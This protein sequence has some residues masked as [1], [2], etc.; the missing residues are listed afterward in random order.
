MQPVQQVV[1]FQTSK[2]HS[3][4]QACR[5]KPDRYHIAAV[6]DN[7]QNCVYTKNR[8]PE[9]MRDPYQAVLN[10]LLVDGLIL[11]IW[12]DAYIVFAARAGMVFEWAVLV[13]TRRSQTQP[14]RMTLQQF[15]SLGT[16][17]DD[18]KKHR[19]AI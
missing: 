2:L 18:T 14:R 10:S 17:G 1:G 8:L 19:G 4:V 13:A 9:Q 12:N 6:L 5:P 11:A 16:A 3:S 7:L 15:A